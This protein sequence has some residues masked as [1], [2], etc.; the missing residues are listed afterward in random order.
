LFA[1]PLLGNLVPSRISFLMAM[2]YYAGNWPF[3]VWL[4]KGESDRKLDRVKQ[5]TKGL[6]LEQ[7]SRFYDRSTAVALGSRLVGWRLMHLHGRALSDLVPQAVAGL[8]DYTWV[9]GEVVCGV[10]LGL[11]LRRRPPARRGVP[12]RGSAAVR[13][14]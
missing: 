7:L 13:V 3:S 11:Q 9:D 10:V 5:A 14:R 6:P 12:H 8:E 2:R 1:I 4:F